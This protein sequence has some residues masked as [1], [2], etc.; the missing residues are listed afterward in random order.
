MVL[1]MLFSL[2]ANKTRTLPRRAWPGL[3]VLGLLLL[4]PVQPAVADSW[5]G[6]NRHYDDWRFGA[7]RYDQWAVRSWRDPYRYS[8][9]NFSVSW[10]RSWS[11]DRY[12]DRYRSH[13]YDRRHWRS[14][15]RHTHWHS[16]DSD[17][18]AGLVGG[19][20]LGSLLNN[21][22]QPRSSNVYST[23]AERRVV[24]S[25]RVSSR[26]MV[27]APGPASGSRLLRDLQGRCFEIDYDGAGNQ[28]RIQVQDSRCH[29]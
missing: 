16:H 22:L 7:D 21:A 11:H 9:S 25:S 2:T 29:F 20:V 3:A 27:R 12:R 26:P 17:V 24:R 13:Y 5:Y 10:G 14:Y 8:G 28:Q 15:N 1:S 23:A 19:L 18:A 4:V 6:F